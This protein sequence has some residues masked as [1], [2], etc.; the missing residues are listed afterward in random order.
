MNLLEHRRQLAENPNAYIEDLPRLT[1]TVVGH[2]KRCGFEKITT[3]RGGELIKK[4][5]DLIFEAQDNRPLFDVTGELPYCWNSPKDWSYN[6]IRYQWGHLKSRNLND[7]PDFLENL[8]LQSARC[9]MHV[10]TSM[11]I[12][13]VI[14]WLKGSAV[15]DRTLAVLEKRSALFESTA[16]RDLTQALNTFR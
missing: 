14:A 8:C 4:Y 1:G 13:E 6:Y 9:N 3:R 12:D 7:A 2:L 5:V 16:W 11:D 10:Q 15:A